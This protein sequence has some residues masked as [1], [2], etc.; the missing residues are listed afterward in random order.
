MRKSLFHQLS[1]ASSSTPPE[2][3]V[4]QV[5][6]LIPLKNSTDFPPLDQICL[7]IRAVWSLPWFQNFLYNYLTIDCLCLFFIFQ[8]TLCR[9]RGTE[10]GSITDN[11]WSCLNTDCISLLI[12]YS[13][14]KNL[15]LPFWIILHMMQKNCK[16]YNSCGLCPHTLRSQVCTKQL[17]SGNNFTELLKCVLSCQHI[18]TLRLPWIHRKFT[19]RHIFSQRSYFFRMHRKL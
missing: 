15:P 13:W 5:S 19:V 18:I 10:Q 4:L 9:S 6:T 2:V 3:Q 11:R 7:I 12:I 14:S 1:T 8:P 16:V 17:R